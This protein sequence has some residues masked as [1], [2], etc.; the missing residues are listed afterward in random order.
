M[1]THRERARDGEGGRKRGRKERGREVRTRRREGERDD[2]V[3]VEDIDR[4]V[5]LYI[6]CCICSVRIWKCH[7]RVAL[8]YVMHRQ[9]NVIRS[10]VCATAKQI[11]E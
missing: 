9:A 1:H 3:G 5:C 7:V 11:T 10:N 8:L 4:D 2:G 6:I